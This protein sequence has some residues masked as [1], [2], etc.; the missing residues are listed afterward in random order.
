MR[1][2]IVLLLAGACNLA[3]AQRTDTLRFTSEAFGTE[4]TV[5]VHLPEFHRLAGPEVRMPVFILLD[6]QHEWFIGPALNDIRF[7]QYTHE[8]P[9]AIVITVPHADRVKECA[10][11]S[12]TQPTTPLLTML[13]Q[14]LPGL[15]TPYHPGDITVLVGHSFSAS[16][17][18]YAYL[19]APAAFD[20][21]IA[22]SPLHQ[23]DRSLPL[24][25]ERLQHAKDE[26]VLLAVGGPERFKDGGH[27][28][29]LTRAMHDALPTR[30][31]DRVFFK[32]YPSA[33]HTS[34]PI[35]AFPD[36]LATLFRPYALRD[37]LAP[38]DENYALLHVPPPPAQ[39]VKELEA[40]WSFLGGTLPWD[41]AEA[42][43]LLS[44]LENGGHPDHVI[45]LLRQAIT[46]YPNEYS[47]HA[48][49][50]EALL[51]RDPAAARSLLMRARELQDA[52]ARDDADYEGTKAAIERMLGP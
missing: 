4:R 20:A 16:F 37:S 21:V 52:Y 36:L 47:F 39:L 11:D 9:Q 1:W 51:E 25:M 8:V 14:E 13:T 24:V 5:L 48:W 41:L 2:S 40:S 30:A 27:H 45:A 6:G 49:L 17:A 43:G 34:L 7:L 31:G 18:L 19:A 29:G 42:N 15:L 26:R 46:F 38:V 12:I 50:G 32:E 3:P 10:P 22:L 44:R 35:I 28:A 23:V 33:G